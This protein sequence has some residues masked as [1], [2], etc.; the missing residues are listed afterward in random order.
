VT[1]SDV[2]DAACP[3]HHQSLRCQSLRC[4]SLRCQSLRCQSLRCHSLRCHSLHCPIVPRGRSG[5]GLWPAI[6]STAVLRL[7]AART[8]R[9]WLA[10]PVIA[11]D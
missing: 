7:T 10:I 11:I 8:N 2:R 4:Q 1:R 9:M 3:L 5:R 6:P